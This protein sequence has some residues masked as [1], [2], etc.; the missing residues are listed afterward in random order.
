MRMTG[1]P[2]LVK[3][4]TNLTQANAKEEKLIVEKFSKLFKTESRLSTFFNQQKREESE[5]REIKAKLYNERS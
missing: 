4:G 3:P 2:S 5:E 1:I